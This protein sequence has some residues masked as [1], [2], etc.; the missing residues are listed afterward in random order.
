M[1]IAILNA[2]NSPTIVDNNLPSRLELLVQ[3]SIVSLVSNQLR[4][5][6]SAV[7]ASLKVADDIYIYI[8]LIHLS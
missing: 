6:D 2:T 5:V 7:V 8:F 4:T 3:D 1:W